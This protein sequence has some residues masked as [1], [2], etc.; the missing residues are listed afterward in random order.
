MARMLA[1][2]QLLAGV[3]VWAE[4]TPPRAVESTEAAPPPEEPAVV[5]VNRQVPAVTAPPQTVSFSLLPTAEEIAK[6]RVF[7]EPI[8]PVRGQPGTLENR[9]LASALTQ[10]IA[11]GGGEH[12]EALEGFLEGHPTSV[13][14]PALLM[15]LGV[16]YRHTGYYSRAL[17][18][19]QEAWAVA[20]GATAP[21]RK[22]SPT[23]QWASWRSF[24]LALAA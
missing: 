10:Y 7:A 1:A 5:K 24:F 2:G 16:V 6:A 19:W 13:W 11:D 21:T 8:V 22:P 4:P 14:R 9:A 20:K 15:N 18:A 3:P 23:R 12:F 17:A